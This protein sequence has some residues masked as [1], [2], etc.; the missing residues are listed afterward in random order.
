MNARKIGQGLWYISGFSPTIKF[1][2]LHRRQSTVLRTVCLCKLCVLSGSSGQYSVKARAQEYKFETENYKIV[3]FV[4]LSFEMCFGQRKYHLYVW[5]EQHSV[6][7]Q[8]R[9]LNL[10]H[11][12]EIKIHVKAILVYQVSL[13]GTDGWV[14]V[15]SMWEEI[16]IPGE[17]PANRPSDRKQLAR[18]PTPRIKPRPYLVRGQSVNHSVQPAGQPYRKCSSLWLGYISCTVYP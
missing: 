15:P 1:T 5:V 10:T 18:V 8:Q 4:P 16:W 11:F 2:H 14:S 6:A 17:H 9:N 3:E 12:T 13:V 7:L